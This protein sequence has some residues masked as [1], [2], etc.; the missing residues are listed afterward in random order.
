MRPKIG[1]LAALALLAF[2]LA[3][4]D[5]CG[6]PVQFKVPGAPKSCYEQTPQK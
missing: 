5:R 6:D 4:C 2:L 1:T 3:G